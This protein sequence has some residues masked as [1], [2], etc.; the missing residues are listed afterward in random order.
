MS[1]T[2]QRH[3]TMLVLVFFQSTTIRHRRATTYPIYLNNGQ[4]VQISTNVPS[5]KLTFLCLSWIVCVTEELPSFNQHVGKS[6]HVV[7]F[8]TPLPTRHSCKLQTWLEHVADM[9][10]SLSAFGQTNRHADI[11][12]DRLR[13]PWNGISWIYPNKRQNQVTIKEDWGYS[14]NK[15]SH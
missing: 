13:C 5:T 3:V 10:H 14:C 1:A 7:L 2:C 9:S 8:W 15:S 11:G 4:Q 6:W 12:H